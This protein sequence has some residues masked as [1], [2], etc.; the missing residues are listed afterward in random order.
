MIFVKIKTAFPRKRRS[1]LGDIGFLRAITKHGGCCLAL[2]YISTSY[3]KKV[4]VRKVPQKGKIYKN[5]LKIV[6]S[7][8][9]QT[10]ISIDFKSN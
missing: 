9:G 6:T 10:L 5:F 7:L 2:D 1:L 4:N 3:E 8:P